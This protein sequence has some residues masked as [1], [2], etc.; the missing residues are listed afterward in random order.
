MSKTSPGPRVTLGKGSGWSSMGFV[1][2]FTAWHPMGIMSRNT[3]AMARHHLALAIE[4]NPISL[5]F[6]VTPRFNNFSILLL[7]NGTK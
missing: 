6:F 7:S 2:G 1:L 5:L 3:P 4:N